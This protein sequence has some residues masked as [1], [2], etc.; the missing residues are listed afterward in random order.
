M[1]RMARAPDREKMAYH[2]TNDGEGDSHYED[3]DYEWWPGEAY[4]D[5]DGSWWSPWWSAGTDEELYWTGDDGWYWLDDWDTE[6]TWSEFEYDE[7]E[8]ST[9]SSIPFTLP[10][11]LLLSSTSPSCCCCGT[12]LATLLA[13]VGDVV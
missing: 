8:D 12:I 5:D 13:L 2:G 4:Y 6:P 9:I 11:P 3:Y 10:L 7:E 1:L